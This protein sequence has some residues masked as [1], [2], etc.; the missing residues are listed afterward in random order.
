L[1][2]NNLKCKKCGNEYTEGIFC[3]E[4]GF[5]NVD[6]V[7]KADEKS[8]QFDEKKKFQEQEQIEAEQKN[9]KET[10]ILM[11]NDLGQEHLG[12]QKN[13][14]ETRT[15]RQNNLE[16]ERIEEQQKKETEHEKTAEAE[17]IH[18]EDAK[19][20]KE[21]NELIEALKSRLMATKSQEE[22]KKIIDGF[23]GKLNCE[24]SVQ[25]LQHLRD[26]AEQS[27]SSASLV[28]WIFG[29]TIIFAFIAACIMV[30]ISDKF[31]DSPFYVIDMLWFV[32]GLPVWI[33]WRIVLFI[34]SKLKS[35]YLNIKHI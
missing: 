13:N 9:D 33:V 28:N 19:M 32:F 1:E 5:K 12:G 14:K 16:Q 30:C 21:D 20:L 25:R 18:Q 24:V 27:P 6:E 11:S 35:Y 4:C 26:K 23:T 17:R 3:P 29:G 22:R 31:M 10:K 8:R 15:L 34:K 7:N 2:G